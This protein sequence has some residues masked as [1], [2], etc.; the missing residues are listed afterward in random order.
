MPKK[1]PTTGKK[2]RALQASTGGKYTTALRAQT[3]AGE[4]NLQIRTLAAA[5]RSAGLTADARRLI[6]IAEWAEERTRLLGFSNV[7]NEASHCGRRIPA[8]VM[9]QLQRIE[10]QT[11]AALD[12]H[13][14]GDYLRDDRE[15][16]RAAALLLAVIAEGAE[17]SDFAD[18][19]SGALNGF[20]P[21][22]AA[23]AIRDLKGSLAEPAAEG[24]D[25]PAAN[26]ARAA[27]S[28]LAQAA[29]MPSGADE[30]WL[31]CATLMEEAFSLVRTLARTLAIEP[32]EDIACCDVDE[33]LV[34]S[35]RKRFD[36]ATPAGVSEALRELT[37]RAWQADGVHWTRGTVHVVYLTAERIYDLARADQ[38]FD[39]QDR[40]ILTGAFVIFEREAEQAQRY[41]D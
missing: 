37:E 39:A 14:D 13:I 2:A 20:E 26:T 19:I 27:A 22:M 21:K 29:R 30:H 6:G 12:A 3:Q 31:A 10:D 41:H 8:A 36:L 16:L 32:E 34:L 1:Q 35:L 40:A 11:S 5:L 7:A 17:R 24:P 38:R 33:E 25:T 4:Q 9:R 28:L 23:D 18:A 15:V